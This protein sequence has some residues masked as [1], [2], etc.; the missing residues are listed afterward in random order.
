VPSVLKFRQPVKKVEL[1]VDG[2]SDDS[3]V[4]RMVR[5]VQRVFR[6]IVGGWRVSVRASARGCWRL[7]LTGAAGRHVWMFAAPTRTLSAA[8]VE[9]LETFLHDSSTPW[10]P[11]PARV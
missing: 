4:S 1:V 11:W 7:E 8:V 5:D 10:R 9:K 2:V 3:I 6:H